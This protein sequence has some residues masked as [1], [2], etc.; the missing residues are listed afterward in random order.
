MFSTVVLG[1]FFFNVNHSCGYVMVCYCGINL[2]SPNY[3]GYRVFCSLPFGHWSHLL[4][5][6]AFLTALFLGNLSTQEITIFNLHL[7]TI[8]NQ[9]LY[10]YLKQYD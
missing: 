1:F 4:F 3:K 2:H 10:Q 8:D 7:F 6:F 9:I 5:V